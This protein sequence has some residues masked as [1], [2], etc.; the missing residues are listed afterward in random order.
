MESTIIFLAH[1]FK[2]SHATMQ[3]KSM[4]TIPEWLC[5]RD[6]VM[7]MTTKNTVEK[8]FWSLFS[9]Q[10]IKTDRWQFS[11]FFH[12]G[13]FSFEPIWHSFTIEQSNILL[14]RTLSINCT[15][16]IELWWENVFLLRTNLSLSF[17]QFVCVWAQFHFLSLSFCYILI[18]CC[19]CWIYS[20]F[21]LVNILAIFLLFRTHSVVHM[22]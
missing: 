10:H 1:T 7:K 8:A 16:L 5:Q 22:L 13:Y 4:R 6:S 12:M 9:F 17:Q 21:E 2:F 14:R 19:C 3:T 15:S 20:A 18:P 11:S